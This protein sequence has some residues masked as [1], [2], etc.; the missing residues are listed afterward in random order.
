MNETIVTSMK[1]KKT[2]NLKEK[3][4]NVIAMHID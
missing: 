4:L 3:K 1:E 2:K